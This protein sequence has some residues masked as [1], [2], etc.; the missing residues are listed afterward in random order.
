MNRLLLLPLLVV[1]LNAPGAADSGTSLH[2]WPCSDDLADL[3][4]TYHQRLDEILLGVGP[5]LRDS[6]EWIRV[7]VMPSFQPEWAITLTSASAGCEYRVAGRQVWQANWVEAVDPDGA[8]RR[9][10]AD[11]AVVVPVSVHSFTLS[12]ETL[13]TLRKVWHAILGRLDATRNLGCDGTSYAFTVSSKDGC[14]EAWSP[15]NE[16]VAGRLVA[17]VD[18]LRDIARVPPGTPEDEID[19]RIRKQAEALLENLEEAERTR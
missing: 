10:W 3:E 9:K 17:I 18:T 5:N 11:Q 14:G 13:E 1:A 15:S 6:D 2:V 4:I 19:T 16:T 7:V 8:K 12:T